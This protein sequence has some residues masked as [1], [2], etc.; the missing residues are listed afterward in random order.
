[1]YNMYIYSHIALN[2][3][4]TMTTIQC[5]SHDQSLSSCGS[6]EKIRVKPQEFQGKSIGQRG[7]RAVCGW[8]DSPPN[9]AARVE[10]ELKSFAASHDGPSDGCG[11]PCHG[12]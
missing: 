3:R 1:M 5:D 4:M 2:F 11:N 6:P 9:G 7:T 12:P 8:G 10:S